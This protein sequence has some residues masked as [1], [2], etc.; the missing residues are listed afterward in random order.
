MKLFRTLTAAGFTGGV[1]LPYWKLVEEAEDGEELSAYA[2][3]LPPDEE[4]RTQFSYGSEHVTHQGAATALWALKRAAE[5]LAERIDFDA[6]TALAWIDAELNRIWQVRGPYP[7]L[8]SALS[9]FDKSL[10][11]TLFCYAL[12][13]LLKDGDDPWEA[14]YAVL[15]GARALTG[16]T[17]V[18]KSIIRKWA[19]LAQRM[20]HRLEALRMLARFDITADQ[21]LRFYKNEAFAAEVV[22]NPYALFERDRGGENPVSFWTVDTGLYAGPPRPPLPQACELDNEDPKDPLRLRAGV[23]E[24]LERAAATGD[25]VLAT[26]PLV[27]AIEKIEAA[28]PVPVDL[29]DL[30][31]FG[32]DFAP[33]VVRTGKTYQLDRYVRYGEL[34]RD[35]V[36]AR[37][38]NP[39]SPPTLN[40]DAIVATKLKEKPKDED[41]KRARREKANALAV[42]SRARIAV[43]TGPAGTGKT[44]VIG[45]LLQALPEG[46]DAVLLAPTGKARVRLQAAAERE[47]KTVAQ[48]LLGHGRYDETSQRYFPTG[49]PPP[50]VRMVI[51]DE[52]SMLTEDQVAALLDAL[53]PGCRVIFVGDPQQLPP[54]GPGRP[55]VDLIRWLTSQPGKPGLAELKIRRRQTD[56]KETR[57][58]LELEDVQFAELFSGRELPAGEDEIIARI[59]GGEIMD[60]LQFI[61]F[62]SGA[63]LQDL[64]QRTIKSELQL[65]GDR[66]KS[67]SLAMGA[68]L[69]AKGNPYFE[70]G[71]TAEAAERW[72]VL[73]PHRVLRGGTQGLNRMI[74]TEFRSATIEFARACNRG[75]RSSNTVSRRRG[76][77]NRSLSATRSSA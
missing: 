77:Q 18:P 43:L 5:R 47:A 13:S 10:N 65:T 49:G 35:A 25:T 8:G 16:R 3:A 15:S 57:R 62:H 36:T 61:R 14:A 21:A 32:D 20:P 50:G 56:S 70:C 37:L 69:S 24:A 26:E 2:A 7:G 59:R 76:G 52:G 58:N 9:A 74:H 29:D 72:Q 28:V 42:L 55:F 4:L 12:S 23:I 44:L 75:G 54:I 19:A 67:F 1:V 60:R 34:I 11:G 38:T 33:E 64:V 22:R 66:A 6:A 48:F 46:R 27:R 51:V 41:E 39:V 73:T 45:M 68:K 17:K 31:L 40:W 63:E 53:E 30:T 71:S